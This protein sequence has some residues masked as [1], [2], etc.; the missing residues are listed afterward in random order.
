MAT[1]SFSTIFRLD[2][3]T[4]V[5]NFEDTSNY[6]GQGISWADISGSFK[7]TAPAAQAGADGMSYSFA[8]DADATSTTAAGVVMSGGLGVAK[9]IYAGANITGSGAST[10][11]IDGFTI[12]G[13]TY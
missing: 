7:I 11:T 3:S 6:T 2:L 12:D 13:G 8:P 9:S 1:I 10:S 4:P 5:F